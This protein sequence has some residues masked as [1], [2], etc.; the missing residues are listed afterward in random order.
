MPFSLCRAELRRIPV[1]VQP[2][3]DDVIVGLHPGDV[4][5]RPLDHL[6]DR[7]RRGAQV[8]LVLLSEVLHLF[9]VLLR[10]EASSGVLYEVG[11][12]LPVKV[13]YFVPL[14]LQIVPG[15]RA[16]HH[17][18]G[19]G[20]EHAVSVLFPDARVGGEGHL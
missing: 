17:V 15:E 9:Q 14:I 2:L 6:L 8:V 11:F 5:L 10:V 16:T 20:S 13:V 19:D 7:A 4:V 3:H 1:R 12:R 18:L